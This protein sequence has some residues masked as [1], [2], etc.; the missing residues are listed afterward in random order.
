MLELSAARVVD[1][2]R[3]D[4][5]AMRESFSHA[6]GAGVAPPVL[7]AAAEKRRLAAAVESA[8]AALFASVVAGRGD[9]DAAAAAYD[10]ALT[11]A[12]ES[13][14]A[15]RVDRVREVVRAAA[16]AAER[17]RLAAPAP[18]QPALPP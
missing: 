11:L 8:K 17:V 6:L 15:A 18:R 1:Q 12:G 14:S 3:A 2:V 4:A 7:V 9:V 10:G 16:A 13:R 5:A